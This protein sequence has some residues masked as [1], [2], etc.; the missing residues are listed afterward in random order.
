MPRASSNWQAYQHDSAE[1][2]RALGLDATVDAT[3]QGTRS[4]HDVDVLV[5]FKAFGLSHRWIVECKAWNRSVPKERVEVLK[6][7]VSETGADRGFLVC[8]KSFQSGAI[9]AARLCNIT[10]TSLEDLRLNAEVDLANLRWENLLKRWFNWHNRW[11][12]VPAA[13]TGR[14]WLVLC[15]HVNAMSAVE[16]G[17]RDFRSNRYPAPYGAISDRPADEIRYLRAGSSEEFLSGAST[18]I[19]AAEDWLSGLEK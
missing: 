3:I 8:E 4:K 18:T 1:F 14:N 5:E 19:S 17:L 7:I 12:E 11:H 16:I 2:F 9:S 10:L 6:S 15:G 13:T